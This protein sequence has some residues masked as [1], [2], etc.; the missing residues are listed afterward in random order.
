MAPHS[1]QRSRTGHHGLAACL[2][3]WYRI[4]KLADTGGSALSPVCCGKP[5]LAKK[6]TP[7]PPPAYGSA[8]FKY[9]IFSPGPS[10][11]SC[12]SC[13]F[14]L[15]PVDWH[16]VSTLE[17]WLRRP[18]LSLPVLSTQLLLIPDDLIFDCRAL[19]GFK[20]VSLSLSRLQ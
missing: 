2:L 3:P 16:F 11:K 6:Q 10:C 4:P 17:F 18:R 1:G 14:S 8:L 9:L 13:A 12:L 20:D 19:D 5:G 7:F 15:P